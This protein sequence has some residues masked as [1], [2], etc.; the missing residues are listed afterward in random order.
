MTARFR[1]WL[2]DVDRRSDHDLEFE[3]C[4]GVSHGT[5]HKRGCVFGPPLRRRVAAVDRVDTEQDSTDCF[6]RPW[7]GRGDALVEDRR[8]LALEG[9]DFDSHTG[10]RRI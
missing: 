4:C 6:G 10:D 8:E 7:L 5:E 9:P 1:D 3:D 2:D